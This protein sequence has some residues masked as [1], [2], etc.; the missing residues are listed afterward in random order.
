MTTGLVVLKCDG[1]QSAR[2]VYEN[3]WLGNSP[4]SHCISWSVGKSFTSALFGCAVAEGRIKSLDDTVTDYCPEFA[5]SGYNGVRLKDVL[6]MSS[7]C[8]W[9]Y[10]RF[11]L[12]FS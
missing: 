2:V 1:V 9:R 5:S 4:T 11:F 12:F 6:Q 8:R 10:V 7:G 3:Y